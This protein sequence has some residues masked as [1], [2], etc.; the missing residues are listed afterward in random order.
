MVAV[1]P[2][3]AWNEGHAR[4]EGCMSVHGCFSRGFIACTADAAKLDSKYTP[5]GDERQGKIHISLS[6]LHLMV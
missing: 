3:G 1:E 4:H 5:I 6:I 2:I